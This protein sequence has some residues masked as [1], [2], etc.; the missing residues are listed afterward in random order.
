MGKSYQYSHSRHEVKLNL[1]A[2]VFI[3]HYFKLYYVYDFKLT[4]AAV[5]AFVCAALHG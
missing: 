5:G 3:F 2:V 4:S 1:T